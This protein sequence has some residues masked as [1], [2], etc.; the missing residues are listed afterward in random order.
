MKDAVFNTL[1]TIGIV[2]GVLAWCIGVGFL[3]GLLGLSQ[4]AGMIFGVILGWPAGTAAYWGF[5]ECW[6]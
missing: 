2:L 5:S 4:G 3:S 6:R 1:L